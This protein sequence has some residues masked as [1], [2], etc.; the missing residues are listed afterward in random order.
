MY[1]LGF[2]YYL[3]F[4]ANLLFLHIL[5]SIQKKISHFYII[6]TYFRIYFTFKYLN[7]FII[8]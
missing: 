7:L 6:E 5:L 4:K 8:N 3:F 2:S 1:Y